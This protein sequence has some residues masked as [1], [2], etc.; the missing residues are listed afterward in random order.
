M[1]KTKL[2]QLSYKVKIK[3]TS[4]INQFYKRKILITGFAIVQKRKNKL[5]HQTLLGT[6]QQPQVSQW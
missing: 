1:I 4:M 3:K 2:I 5:K 6:E